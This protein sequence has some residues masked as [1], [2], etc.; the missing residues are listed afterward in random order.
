MRR[1]AGLVLLVVAQ[2]AAAKEH[3]DSGVCITTDEGRAGV[4]FSIRNS[5]P[6]PVGVRLTFSGLENAEPSLAPDALLVVGPSANEHV[7]RLAARDPAQSYRYHFTWHFWLGDPK[8]RHDDDARYRMPFGGGVPRELSQGAN[9]KFSH[10]GEYAFDFPM[11]IG[12]PVL[13]AREGIVVKV[14]DRYERGAARKSLA[15]QANVIVVAHSDGTFARYVHIKRGAAVVVGQR[16]AAGELLGLSGN[17]GF[18]AQPHL[19]FEVYGAGPDGK[20]DTLPIR[21][22]SADPRGFEPRE[23]SF[24]PP[25]R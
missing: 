5:L 20:P 17:T 16:V 15:D 24:Y 14:V 1:G 11:P 10:R 8:A 2:A 19:H 13:T 7:A 22:E 4:E 6:T 21:F 12:T 23:G 25:Q 9:G 18:T 3:C